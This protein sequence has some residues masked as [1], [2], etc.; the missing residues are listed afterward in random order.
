MGEQKEKKAIK[1]TERKSATG[2]VKKGEGK[3]NG[4][5]AGGWGGVRWETR[6]QD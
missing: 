6:G 2:G 4:V 1:T 5:Q 3:T